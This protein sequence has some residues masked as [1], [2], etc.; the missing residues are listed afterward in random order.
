VL[1]FLAGGVLGILLLQWLSYALLIVIGL[2]LSA[3]ALS[4]LKRAGSNPLHAR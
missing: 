3:L 4:A 2:L 1:A